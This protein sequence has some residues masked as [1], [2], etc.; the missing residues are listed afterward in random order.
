MMELFLYLLS[1]GLVVLG[2]LAFIAALRIWGTFR[3]ILAC[4]AACVPIAAGVYLFHASGFKISD[5]SR[6]L[7]S[8]DVEMTRTAEGIQRNRTTEEDLMRMVD[9]SSQRPKR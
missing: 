5:W 2:A 3:M 4:L 9:S 7:H 1:A 6:L 8:A